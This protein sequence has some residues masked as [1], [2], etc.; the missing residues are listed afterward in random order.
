[1]QPQKIT[2]THCYVQPLV[3]TVRAQFNKDM[4]YNTGGV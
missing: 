4:Y 3:I 1:M 2:N